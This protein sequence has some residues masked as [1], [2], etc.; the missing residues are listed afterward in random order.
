LVRNG[1]AL[2]YVKYSHGK[3]AKEETKAKEAKAGLWSGEFTPPWQWRAERRSKS[4]TTGSLPSRDCTIK[5]NIS[6]KGARIYHRPGQRDYE[7]TH[8]TERK[9][10]RWF[11]SEAEAQAAG[12]RPSS[13]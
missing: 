3:Y 4:E 12:W 8:I 2:D 7:K 13:Q 9:G 11:C 10:E 1:F 6:K 5:G